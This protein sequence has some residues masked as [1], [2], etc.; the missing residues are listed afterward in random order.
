MGG[1]TPLMM[2]VDEGHIHVMAILFDQINQ[3][4]RE[5]AD[6]SIASVSGRTV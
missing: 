4:G 2:A 1:E 3:E 5:A 6:I